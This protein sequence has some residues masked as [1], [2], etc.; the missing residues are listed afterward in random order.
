MTSILGTKTLKHDLK[1]NTVSDSDYMKIRKNCNGDK[2]SIIYYYLLPI[3][4]IVFGLEYDDTE[5]PKY[6]GPDCI[7]SA[8]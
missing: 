8:V 3:S 1:A 7:W 6:L 5:L 2:C 4:T